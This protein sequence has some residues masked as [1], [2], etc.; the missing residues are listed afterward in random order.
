MPNSHLEPSLHSV[1]IA[2][3]RPTQITVG[4]R[5]VMRKRHEWSMRQA[6]ER[7][8]FLGRHMIPVVVGPKE[9]YWIIDHHHLARALHDEGVENVLVSVAARLD[10]LK[11]A[12]FLTFMDNRNW[13]HPFDG[14]GKRQHY[15]A[16][17]SHIDQLSDDPYRS[18]SGAL[19]R[20]GGYA[21]VDTP[22]SEFLWADF[23][24]GSIKR[25]KLDNRFDDCVVEALAIANSRAAEHLPG[26]AGVSED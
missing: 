1:P 13:L 26:W 12:A 23:L 4:Y 15:D 21:K 18:L 5:E 24:R 14:K 10:H 8:G 25:A 9:R 6:D 3:L 20:A 17:P 11:P 2:S 19:R 16:I 7:P 22:Y